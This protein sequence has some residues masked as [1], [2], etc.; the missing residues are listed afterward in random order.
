MYVI[1][2]FVVIAF[3]LINPSFGFKFSNDQL[4]EI[5]R[6]KELTEKLTANNETLILTDSIKFDENDISFYVYTRNDTNG[7]EVYYNQSN[8]LMSLSSFDPNLKT[9]VITHG[10][11]NT[12]ESPVDTLL[13]DSLLKIDDLN[14]LNVNWDKYAN[15]IYLESVLAVPHV[16]KTLGKF[17]QT[18]SENFNYPLDNF[19]LMGHSL[20]AHISGF[21]GQYL[22]GSL[23]HI[24]G[25]DPAGPLFLELDRNNR[26]SED[27]A[28]YV[29]A[30]H[31]NALF[32]GVNYNVGHVDFWPNGG[33]AQP[34]CGFD[35]D[36][37]CSHG[38]SY[39]YMAESL[40]DNQ[41]LARCCSNYL[42]Y[43]NE[44]CVNNTAGLMGG[45]VYDYSLTGDLYLKTNSDS[46]YGLG[47]IGL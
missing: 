40:E 35:W 15:E 26:L 47:D 44:K 18:V 29:Q 45:Y 16:G 21:A 34:G 32:L 28:Q 6:Y 12:Y 7:T 9:V 31:T 14:V 3:I 36:G 37:A 4:S 25:M 8:E 46:P 13:K 2:E 17:I 39:I 24:I 30:I 1:V 20:G 23:P 41:F 43:L 33:L 19:T 11:Y 38:R 22:N 42:K 10:W 27:D 5:R